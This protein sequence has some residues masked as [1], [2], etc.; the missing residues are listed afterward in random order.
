[1]FGELSDVETSLFVGEDEEPLRKTI[2]EEK[3]G[4]GCDSLGCRLDL[5]PCA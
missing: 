3:N 5:H 2:L 4:L 1:M